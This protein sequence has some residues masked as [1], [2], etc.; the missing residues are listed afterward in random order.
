MAELQ[1]NRRA[2][3]A[4]MASLLCPV[5]LD[6]A[7]AQQ[8]ELSSLKLG[9][10][11]RAHLYY[12][13]VTIA[14][15][16]GHFRDYGLTVTMSDFEGGGQAFDALLAGTVD[17]AAGAY[18]HTLRAQAMGQDVG[19]VIELGRFPGVALAV[20]KDRPF[21]S[22]PDLKGLSIGVTARALPA[23]SLCSI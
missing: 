22:I 2:F 11:N 10:A 8:L 15:R 17:V 9:V 3:T 1:Y 13:P 23:T 19:A 16:R 14:D 4:G 7:G 12:L 5:A 20:G 21:K 18:E 6:L